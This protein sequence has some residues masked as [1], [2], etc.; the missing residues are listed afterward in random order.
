MSFIY[1]HLKTTFRAFIAM[2]DEI[3]HFEDMYHKKTSF[4]LPLILFIICFT[5]TYLSCVYNFC[6]NI[7]Y[8]DLFGEY[9]FNLF[10]K[11]IPLSIFH[12]ALFL[13]SILFINFEICYKYNK[14]ISFYYNRVKRSIYVK[15]ECDLNSFIRHE[16]TKILE[17]F[18]I[19]DNEFSY[20]VKT[21]NTLTIVLMLFINLSFISISSLNLNMDFEF[22]ICLYIMSFMSNLYLIL[23]QIYIYIRKYN[24]DKLIK[25][26]KY[27]RL[28]ISNI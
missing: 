14:M 5:L 11:Q 15:R 9:L 28:E 23:T 26:L 7:I 8:Q 10:K 13:F 20:T 1:I 18:I 3:S 19:N 16:I 12:S 4:T 6:F 21:L 24:Q 27:W 25:L 22:Y 2:Y 17:K